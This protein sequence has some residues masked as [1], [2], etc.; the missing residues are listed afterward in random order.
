MQPSP[1][2]SAVWPTPRPLLIGL[3]LCLLTLAVYRPVLDSGFVNY[4]DNVYV[5]SNLH[6]QQGLTREGFLWAWQASVSANWHPLTVL[7]HMLDVEL[8]GL[9]PRGHHLT[10]LL[11]HLANVW[12]LFAILRR[13]TGAVWRSALVAA[14]FAVHPTHVESV[15]WISERKDVLSGL[16]FLLTLWAWH[17]Y[18]RQRSLGPFGRGQAPPL[19]RN[20]FLAAVTFALGLLSKPMLVTLPF[21]LLLID[22]W[23]LGRLPRGLWPLLAEKIPLLVLAAVS[24]AVTVYVQQGPIASLQAVSLGQRLA[25]ALVSYA[26]YLGK[27]FWPR[28]L[29]V[30]YPFRLAIPLWQSVAAAALLVVLTVLALAR[31]RRAPWLTTGWLWFVGMLVPVIGLVQ[32]GR[33][34]MADRY[35]YL[36]SIGL[37]LAVVWGIAGLLRSERARPVLAAASMLAVAALA[38]TAHVQARTW[39]DSETLFRHALA[40]TEDNYLAHLN[41]GFDLARQGDR[42]EAERHFR[43]SLRLQPN[44]I[45][46]HAGLGTNLRKWGRPREALP[47]LQRVV[48]MRPRDARYRVSLASALADLGRKEEAMAQLRTALDLSPR[49]VDAHQGLAALLQEQGRTDEALQ[50]YLAA[51]EEDPARLAVYSPAATLL[52]QKGDLAG[53]ARLLAEALRRQPDS[54]VTC[55]NLGVTFERMGRLADA[56]QTYAHCLEIDPGLEPAR[57]RLELLGR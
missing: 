10:N 39:R 45:E 13:M 51:L 49:F 34:A 44:L 47:H 42:A 2:P 12:L 35:T 53:A 26:A 41:L 18:T 27:T 6:V 4:D 56:R 16:F 46:A 29:A 7:S 20:Y 5:T 57:Q 33:Q 14:L 23:P 50:H 22:V 17:A 19:L 15:A 43:E 30:F 48:A 38:V 25:N 40:V 3:I 55:Y 54:A 24:S 32:V 11:L 21:V 1:S 9:N 31:L 36:P 28:H 52:A 37:Y 8:Y